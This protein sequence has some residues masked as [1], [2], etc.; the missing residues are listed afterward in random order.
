M[1]FTHPEN[2]VRLLLAAQTQGGGGRTI[3]DA[4]P[5]KQVYEH[6]GK[7]CHFSLFWHIVR[8][9]MGAY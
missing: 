6:L 5:Y 7:M 4:G 9:I 3:G 2:G 1:T 8:G